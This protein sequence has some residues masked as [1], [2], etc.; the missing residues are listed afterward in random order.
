MASLLKKTKKDIKKK[1]SSRIQYDLRIKFSINNS[2]SIYRDL[3]KQGNPAQ[4]QCQFFFKFLD[5]SSNWIYLGRH[6]ANKKCYQTI[7][8]YLDSQ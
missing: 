7:R 2:T 6:L 3:I 1:N 4:R 5:T 8:T